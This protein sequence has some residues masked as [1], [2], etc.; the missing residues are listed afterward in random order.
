[1]YK[2]KVSQR[3]FFDFKLK[4]SALLYEDKILIKLH[5]IDSDGSYVISFGEGISEDAYQLFNEFM[6]Q[7]K[8]NLDKGDNYEDD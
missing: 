2:I 3:D 8:T 5:D 4:H 7:K 6:K 1:M